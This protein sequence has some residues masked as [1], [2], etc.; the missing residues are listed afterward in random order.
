MDENNE[1]DHMD[2][3][4]ENNA[5]VDETDKKLVRWRKINENDGP[6]PKPRH[7]HRAVV[8]RDLIVIFGGGNE[9]MIDELHVYNTETREWVVPQIRGE[10]PHPAAAFGA[11]A[12]GTKVY[13][14]GGMVE[15]G[16]YSNDVYELTATRWEWRRM[17]TKVMGKDLPPAPRIG[18]SFVVSEKNQKAYMFGGLCNDLNDNKRNIPRYMN[19]LYVLDLSTAPNALVWSKPEIKGD[20]PSARESHTA[21]LYEN[22]RVSRMVVYGGMDGNRLGDLWYLDLNTLQWTEMKITDPRHGFPPMPRSLHTSV[23]IGTKMFVYGGWVPVM[24]TAPGEQQDKEWKCTSSLGCWDVEENRWVPLQQYD[25]DKD[26]EPRARSGHC[27]AAMG[28]RMFIWSGRDGYRK[29]WSNQVCCRDMWVLETMKP[30]QSAKVQLGRAGFS[31]LEVSWPPV[32]GATGYFLQIGFGDP[33]DASAS[34]AKRGQVSP[35]KQPAAA[36]VQKEDEQNKGVTPSLISTQGTTYTTPA[37]SKPA[38]GEG[39]LPQDLFEDSEKNEGTSTSP[40]PSGDSQADVDS[41]KRESSSENAT[42]Q[43]SDSDVKKEIGEEKKKVEVQFENADDDLPWFDVGIIKNASIN[44]T[45]YFNARQQPLE[46]QLHDL[47]EHN[48]FKCINEP[49]FTAEDKVALI[50]GQTYRFRVSAINGLGKGAWSETASFKTCVPG[51]PSAPSSIRITK[52]QDGAQLTWEPP[53]NT[54]V[55]GKIIEYSVY[56]AVKSQTAN[57]ADSQLAF[58]RV[59]CGPHAECQVPQAN[60]GTAYVDQ[61]NKPAI[62]FRIAA[63]NE[64][65]Y[66][67]ATQVRWLQDQQKSMPPRSFPNVAPGY[68]YQHATPHLKKPRFEHH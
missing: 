11:A 46:K 28:D 4:E 49:N 58:M 42:A 63:K 56:L 3:H 38:I 52:S 45:H 22:D 50:N 10:A 53:S 15:Y 23:L 54:N 29:A 14:F 16:K 68:L 21:V 18:H 1:L 7:G 13:I 61:T 48:A 40:K 36:T 43:T 24:P 35:R 5:P 62:I 59:Y 9:G 20:Q 39:G 32:P 17:T 27:A 64:K 60:L 19:D 6:T 37:P 41:K 2:Y 66:G 31:S 65:G 34:P 12:F 51:Y 26:D 8:I 44:V 33:K 67:P 57:P 47:V 25:T 30:E 55:S